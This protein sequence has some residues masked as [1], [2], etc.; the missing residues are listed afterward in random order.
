[1]KEFYILSG[2]IIAICLWQLVKKLFLIRCDKCN[3]SMYYSETLYLE[4]EYYDV[5]VCPKCDHKETL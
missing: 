2:F 3:S 4:G 5:F 1:M